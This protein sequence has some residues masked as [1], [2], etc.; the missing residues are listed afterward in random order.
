MHKLIADD[1]K[2]YTNGETY[3]KEICLPGSADAS[4][5]WQVNEP[6]EGEFMKYSVIRIIE[7]MRGLGKYEEF[8]AML[9]AA[10]LDWDFVGANYMAENHPSFVRMC[11][12]LVESGIV[13]KAQ[14]DEMLPKCIWSAD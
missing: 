6:I 7:A 13:T 11:A 4:A 12:A 2:V 9:E 10:R 3:G 8:R 1:G 5:W 14:L